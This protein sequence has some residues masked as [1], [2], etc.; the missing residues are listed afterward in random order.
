[1]V[2]IKYNSGTIYLILNKNH[3]Y[4]TE[5]MLKEFVEESNSEEQFLDNLFDALYD[6]LQEEEPMI[7]IELDFTELENKIKKWKIYK[8]LQ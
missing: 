7:L 3:Y 2:E 8:N 1:M 4:I 6:Y 5:D